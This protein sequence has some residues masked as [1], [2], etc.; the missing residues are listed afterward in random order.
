MSGGTIQSARCAVVLVLTL[1]RNTHAWQLADQLQQPGTSVCCREPTT[2]LAVGNGPMATVWTDQWI[3]GRKRKIWHADSSRGRARNTRALRL[4]SEPS[5]IATSPCVAWH[6]TLLAASLQHH[7]VRS[8]IDENQPRICRMRVG[9]VL[10]ATGVPMH[11]EGS[12]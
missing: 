10:S 1:P 5:F 3:R 6:W 8:G 11:A 2:C 7:S 4:G 9:V 12:K